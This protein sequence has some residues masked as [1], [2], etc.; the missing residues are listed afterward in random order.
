[1]WHMVPVLN[2]FSSNSSTIVLCL[3][4]LHTRVA[5]SCTSRRTSTPLAAAALAAITAAAAAL[6]A[7]SAACCP[8][9]PSRLD[10][11]QDL[12]AIRQRRLQEHRQ[13]CG[14]VAL[15]VCKAARRR[16][17][18]VQVPPGDAGGR[19]PRMCAGEHACRLR[20][21]MRGGACMP[22]CVPAMLLHY[23]PGT[24]ALFPPQP[25]PTQRRRPPTRRR[26]AA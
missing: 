19:A 22:A 16:Q 2:E 6:A 25:A 11:Q 3:P 10:H 17:L 9:L 18:A 26:R 15:A 21:I 1:M 7:L 14:A 20:C 12:R 4:F 24:R 8:A 13:R 23:N 5:S